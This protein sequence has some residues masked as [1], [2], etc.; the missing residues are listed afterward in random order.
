MKRKKQHCNIYTSKTPLPPVSPQQ[1]RT[2]AHA[3][4]RDPGT[5]WINKSSLNQEKK[6]VVHILYIVMD[7]QQRNDTW[8]RFICPPLL[9]SRLRD[10]F[11]MALAGG[12]SQILL[13]LLW[14]IVNSQSLEKKSFSQTRWKVVWVSEWDGTGTGGDSSWWCKED[15]GKVAYLYIHR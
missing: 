11:C 2:S 13:G 6:S 5:Q 15:L 9:V 12:L 7:E 10:Q 1:K 4:G 14:G 8:D 3:M